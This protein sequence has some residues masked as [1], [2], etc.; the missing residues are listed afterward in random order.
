[1]LPDT[2]GDDRDVVGLDDG[3][4]VRSCVGVVTCRRGGHAVATW[5]RASEG[6]QVR[7]PGE[8]G[9]SLMAEPVAPVVVVDGSAIQPMTD[10]ELRPGPCGRPAAAI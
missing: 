8:G 6:L 7:H 9:E 1:M 10:A 4:R 5:D 3:W 2:P